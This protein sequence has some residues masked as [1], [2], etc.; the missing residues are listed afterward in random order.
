MKRRGR[1][2]ILIFG[3]AFLAF[4]G[5]NLE[6]ALLGAFGLVCVALGVL[7]IF[8]HQQKKQAAKKKASEE[9]EI[10]AHQLRVARGEVGP[11]AH[12]YEPPVSQPKPHSRPTA[13]PPHSEA[14]ALPPQYDESPRAQSNPHYGPITPP[15]QSP[16]RS[17]TN[18]AWR[19][20][21]AAAAVAILIAA[22]F[23]A[24]KPAQTATTTVSETVTVTASPEAQQDRPVANSSDGVVPV[25]A[26]PCPIT[27]DSSEFESSA[28]GT[29]TTSCAFAEAVRR[30]YID[31]PVRNGST[32]VEAFS[33]VTGLNYKMSCSGDAVVRCTGGRNADIYIY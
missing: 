29:S 10:R 3:G 31:N 25:G 5:F 26:T 2:I 15:S 32:V 27:F 33:P 28:L 6:Q 20:A 18:P 11:P 9:A 4:I 13:P 14:A 7:E 21:V 22:V 19:W 8:R 23:Y 24:L 17:T 12:Y 1:P 16:S 30:A